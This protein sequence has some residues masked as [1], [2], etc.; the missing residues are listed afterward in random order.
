MAR[1]PSSS[2]RRACERHDDAGRERD[3]RTRWRRFLEAL[4][5]RGPLILVF[6]DLHWADDA[7][8]D[9]VDQLAA[10]VTDVPLFVL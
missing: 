7:L 4:A 5:E 1:W 10:W 6:E 3:E 8:L 2:P 9:F